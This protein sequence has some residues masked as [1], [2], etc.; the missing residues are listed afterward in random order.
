MEGHTT[1]GS[2]TLF[3]FPQFLGSTTYIVNML[4]KLGQTWEQKKEDK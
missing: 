1:T 3:K 4:L 2:G